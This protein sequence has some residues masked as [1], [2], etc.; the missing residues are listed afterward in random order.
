MDHRKLD[1]TIESLARSDVQVKQIA[2]RAPP[3][4]SPAISSSAVKRMFLGDARVSVLDE[5]VINTSMA[6]MVA[7]R[8]RW[9]HGSL[10]TKARCGVGAMQTYVERDSN[11]ATLG[12]RTRLRLR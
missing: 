9:Y 10:P 7:M 5:V 6:N 11:F 3:I 1:A 8:S 12:L 2:E 4:A